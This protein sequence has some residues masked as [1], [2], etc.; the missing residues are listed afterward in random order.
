MYRIIDKRANG[1]SSRLILLA[2]EMGL[3]IA[4]NNPGA[5]RQKALSYGIVGVEFIS[6][7][8]IIGDNAKGKCQ[9]VLIDELEAFVR[10]SLQNQ[11]LKGYT[12][13]N[14]D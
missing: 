4:C 1:K 12:L 6:Y 8:D 14:E 13:S 10:Y 11:S 2:K 7:N 3:P 9:D 5:M